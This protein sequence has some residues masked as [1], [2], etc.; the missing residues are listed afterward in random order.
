MRGSIYVADSAQS[1]GNK[2]YAL[3]AHWTTIVPDAPAYTAVVILKFESAAEFDVEHDV[4]LSL[5]SLTDESGDVL[6]KVT[7][8]VGAELRP[9][10]ELVEGVPATA[11]MCIT[12]GNSNRAPGSYQWIL[13]VDGRQLDSWE[14]KILQSTAEDGDSESSVDG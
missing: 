10:N 4:E 9:G 12:I 6:Q 3:G 7:G 2:V 8:K 14:F 5:R 13:T 1:V 11:A